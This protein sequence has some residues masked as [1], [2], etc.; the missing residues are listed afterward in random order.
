MG[1]SIPSDS[2]PMKYFITWKIIGA[3]HQYPIASENAA[4]HILREEPRTLVP[5]LRFP[6]CGMLYRKGIVFQSVS[7]SMGKYSKAHPIGENWNLDTHT[8]SKTMVI[9]FHEIST[10]WYSKSDEKCLGFPMNF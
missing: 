9:S 2:Y 3:P 5:I 7:D 4:K 6:S 8:F 10:L 1:G